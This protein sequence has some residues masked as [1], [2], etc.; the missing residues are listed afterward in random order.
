MLDEEQIKQLT[1][2]VPSTETISKK[3]SIAGTGAYSYRRY[4]RHLLT[5]MATL[6]RFER[7]T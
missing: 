4:S 7:I 5:I 3:F 1:E 6:Y 2:I